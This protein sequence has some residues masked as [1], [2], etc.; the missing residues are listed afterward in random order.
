MIDYFEL[1]YLIERGGIQRLSTIMATRAIGRLSIF[2]G[3]G[4]I[5]RDATYYDGT[6]PQSL[7]R[8]IIYFSMAVKRYHQLRP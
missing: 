4:A 5:S 6:R 2:F 8:A 7:H 3:I 1:W